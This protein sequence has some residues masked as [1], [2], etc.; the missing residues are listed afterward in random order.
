MKPKLRNFVRRTYKRGDREYTYYFYVKSWRPR[1]EVSLGSD[2]AE[3]VQKWAELQKMDVTEVKV[4]AITLDYVWEQYKQAD[5]LEKSPR[6]RKDYESYYGQ[7]KAFFGGDAPFAR[8]ETKH[9][10]QFKEKR[11]ARVR[12]NRERA[13]FS[14]LWFYAKSRGWV[15]GANPVEGVRTHT[16]DGRDVYVQ[17]EVVE[18]VREVGDV[19]LNRAI[20]LA[21]LTGL[22]PGDVVGLTLRNIQNGYLVVRASKT[23]RSS[24]MKLRIRLT[25]E[26]RELV[27]ELVNDPNRSKPSVRSM[28]LL[29]N[30]RGRALTYSALDNRYD[31]A[32][33]KACAAYPELAEEI[34]QAQFR[35]LRAKAGTDVDRSAGW[36]MRT[37]C[38]GTRARR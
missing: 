9:L 21:Y 12:F 11:Q 23:K 1:E 32:R 31:R 30:E 38:W 22:R 15:S 6:T 33:V 24:R 25:G 5:F 19:P 16:E 35:D 36:P 37:A 34:R 7:L 27:E 2:Y 4:S 18:A 8:I 3:A 17:D 13:L 28:A 14:I 26:L 29:V 10:Q 20:D